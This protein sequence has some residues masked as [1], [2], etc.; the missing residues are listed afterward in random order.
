[1]HIRYII[2]LTNTSA[3]RVAKIL[4]PPLTALTDAVARDIPVGYLSKTIIPIYCLSKHQLPAYIIISKY[5]YY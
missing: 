4:R 5:N 1:M 3:A 2:K